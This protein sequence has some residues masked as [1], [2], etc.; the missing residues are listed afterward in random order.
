MGYNKLRWAQGD[1]K[2]SSSLQRLVWRQEKKT[3]QTLILREDKTYDWWLKQVR[4]ASALRHHAQV[5]PLAW[6]CDLR[7]GLARWMLR[8]LPASIVRVPPDLAPTAQLAHWP[9]STLQGVTHLHAFSITIEPRTQAEKENKMTAIYTHLSIATLNIK[10]LNS[11]VKWHRLVE[12]RKKQ[13]PYFCC[14]CYLQETHLAF[15][16]RYTSLK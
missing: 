16:D 4:E 8:S 7:T 10:G 14:C 11:P 9:S 15:K 2:T 12:W 13:N 3:S 6:L 5:S 1:F